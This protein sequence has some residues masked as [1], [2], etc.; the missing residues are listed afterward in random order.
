[1]EEDVVILVA[2]DPDPVD[3]YRKSMEFRSDVTKKIKVGLLRFEG[4]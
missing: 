4:L 2:F 3:F 1:M